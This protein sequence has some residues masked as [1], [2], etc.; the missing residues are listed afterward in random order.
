MEECKLV[1]LELHHYD[2]EDHCDAVITFD[3]PKDWLMTEYGFE[4]DD[5][6]EKFLEE[7]CG[8]DS[9]QIYNLALLQG[10]IV[11]ETIFG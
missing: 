5:A 8:E 9:E 11:H 10:N 3:V 4:T 7:Y 6:L 1:R 2:E